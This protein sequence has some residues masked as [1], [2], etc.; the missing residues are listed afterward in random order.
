M[1]LEK[2]LNGRTLI[3]NAAASGK[4]IFDTVFAAVE[5]LLTRPEVRYPLWLIK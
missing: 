5:H 4:I 3:A 2:D 1:I